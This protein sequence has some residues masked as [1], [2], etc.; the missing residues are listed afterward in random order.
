MEEI[1][2]DE[3]MSIYEWLDSIPLTKPKKNI[4]RDFSDGQLLAE[5]IKYYL[6]KMIDINNYPS[7]SNTNQKNYNWITLN[8]KVLKKINVKL[9]KNE[10]DDI[11]SCKNLA[12]EHLLNKVYKAI[13]LYS[14]KTIRIIKN[15]K[16]NYDNKMRE[17]IKDIKVELE[18]K[19]N[20]VKN[21]S[22]IIKTL[23]QKLQNATMNKNNLE[24]RIMECTLLLRQRG[25]N[26]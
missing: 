20:E 2:E 4:A 8:N 19:R 7:S 23:Q 18:I 24:K 25:A 11:I 10:I 1:S 13:E 15:K 22:N 16:E 14:G 12:I 6:P 9:S 5:I 26:I 17:N 21:L 3:L